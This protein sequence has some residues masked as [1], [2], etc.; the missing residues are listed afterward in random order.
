MG[1]LIIVLPA[2][3]ALLQMVGALTE[4]GCQ[5]TQGIVL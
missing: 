2:I 5:V 4:P 3:V 1:K